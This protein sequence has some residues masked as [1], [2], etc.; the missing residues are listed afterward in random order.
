MF[1]K[2]NIILVTGAT[3]SQGGAVAAAL[4]KNGNSVRVIVRQSSKHSKAADELENAGA[5]VV[6]ADMDDITSI[7]AAMAGVY[8]LFSV[9][10]MDNGTNSERRHADTLVAAALK[11]GIRHVVHASVNQTGNHE[12]FPDWDTNRWNKKYWL[13]K[14]YAEET[15]RNASFKHWT[16]LRP[17]FFMDNFIAP[18]VSFMFPNLVNAQIAVAWKPASKL[19]L[20]AVEDTGT[21]AAA[22]FNNVAKFDRHIIDLAGD[23]LTIVEIAEQITKVTG[24]KINVDCVSEAEAIKRGTHPGF[25]NAQEWNNYVGYNADIKSLKNHR[26]PTTSFMQYLQKNRNLLPL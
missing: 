26:L 24:K 4:L 2:E 23:E 14:Q 17:V 19:Q 12:S 20:I 21:F 25:A 11:T 8:G 22:A 18:K 1:K 3:G 7:E 15:I 13:D 16:I 5:E 6:I 10:G 9:Q